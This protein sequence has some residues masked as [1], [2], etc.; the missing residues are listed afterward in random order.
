MTSQLRSSPQYVGKQFRVRAY[1]RAAQR[2]EIALDIQGETAFVVSPSAAVKIIALLQNA[3][4]ET[5]EIGDDL[6]E[7][8]QAERIDTEE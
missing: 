1:R 7:H 2:P 4:K 3:V 5:V 8:T 6:V